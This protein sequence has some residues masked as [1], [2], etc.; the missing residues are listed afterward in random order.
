[1]EN[2]D[3]SV[4]ER[5]A[6][7][8][9]KE[10]AARLA[11]LMVVAEEKGVFC[12]SD[13]EIVGI[14]IGHVHLG[15]G[16][17]ISMVDVDAYYDMYTADVTKDIIGDAEHIYTKTKKRF[18]EEYGQFNGQAATGSKEGETEA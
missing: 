12:K 17:Y 10:A 7:D 18:R 1:M 6:Y 16:A 15:E 5:E 14:G 9:E 8:W 4:E 13:F 2:Q 3:I 11:L